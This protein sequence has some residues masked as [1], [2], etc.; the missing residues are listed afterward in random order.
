M[1]YH[2]TDPEFMERFE[3]FAFEEVPGEEG[4]RRK[5][6]VIWPS[7]RCSS[8]VRERRPLPRCFPKPWTEA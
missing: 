6:T 1:N 2:E 8:A 4:Q 3:H 5:R 7:W